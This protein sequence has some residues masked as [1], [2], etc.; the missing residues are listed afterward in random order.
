MSKAKNNQT[1]RGGGRPA[2]SKN[3]NYPPLKLADALKVA[4]TIEDK[5]SG[6][7]TSRLTLAKL[8]DISP[9]SSN[10]SNLVAASRMYGLTNGGINASEFSL[11]TLGKEATGADEVARLA[12]Y[13]KAVVNIAPYRAFFQAF[14][15]KKV[16]S[17]MP[18]T[19]FLV[20]TADVEQDRA[21]EAMALIL[22]DAEKAGFVRLMKGGAPWIDLAGTPTSPDAEKDA[23]PDA[24]VNAGGENG[25][26]P[27][28]EP[29]VVITPIPTSS[30]PTGKPKKVFIAHGKNRVPLEQLKKALDTFKVSYAVAVD[31]A[32]QGRP[33]SKKVASLMRDECSSG[34]FIFTA[35]ER[36]LR[37]AKSGDPEEVWRPSEN[38]VY[39]LGAASILYENRI[40]IFK[41]K[42]L[43]FPT[44][45]SDL[46]FIEFEK[47]QLV[48]ELGALF[49][50]L[51]ELDILEVRAKG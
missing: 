41:E 4:Q 20:K 43:T 51:V 14:N 29:A 31:E 39:E 10:F 15:N 8:L 49:K 26:R 33:I 21:D 50:E 6:V 42:G 1:A 37:E 19:D 18:F 44:D 35:D 48:A 47:D 3:R 16:P 32:N 11:T 22:A 40:V 7:T 36:F 9:A 34:I 13:K 2:G 30:A 17:A 28:P 24:G 25:S 23:E 45:F 27:E 38:V 12:A 5:A 46:G